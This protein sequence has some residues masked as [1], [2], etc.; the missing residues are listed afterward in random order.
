VGVNE[1]TSEGEPMPIPI[2][3]V[4]PKVEEEQIAR[5][6]KLRRERNNRKV[7]ETLEKLHYAAE[8]NENLMPTIIK[9]VKAYAT[10][11]EICDVLREVYGVYK[12][13]II[14]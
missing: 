13:L 11:G 8:N 7:K 2:L 12:E 5:L 10:L 4:D 14:I 6:K 1:Y 3:R 9:A